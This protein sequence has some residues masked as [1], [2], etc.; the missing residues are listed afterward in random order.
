[1]GLSLEFPVVSAHSVYFLKSQHVSDI[2]EGKWTVL[3]QICAH[4]LYTGVC[5][6]FCECDSAVRILLKMLA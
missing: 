5:V 2:S 4:L 3:K 1:M 6:C